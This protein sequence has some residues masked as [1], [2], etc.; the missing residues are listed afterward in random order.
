VAHRRPSSL[1]LIR[2]LLLLVGVLSLLAGGVRAQ[3]EERIVIVLPT[4]GVVDQIMATYLHE[5]IQRGV[6]QGAAAVV[7]ELDTPGGSLESTREIV[8]SELS[9]EVPV[10]VWV[11]PAG[12]RA[13]SAGTFLTLASHVA[14]MAPATNI[15]AATP[16]SSDG[17]DIPDDLGKKVMN[18]TIAT[19]TSIA[20]ERGRPVDWAITTV[21]DAAS[22][23]VDEALAAG[24]IDFKAKSIEDLLAQA[25]GMTVNVAG[26]PVVLQTAGA[27]IDEVGMNP[28]QAFLHLLSDPNIA[29]ILFTL[30]FYGI[31]FELQN[32]NY[33]TGI[34]GAFALILAFIGFGSLPLN[35]AGLLLIAFAVILFVLELSVTS[36]GLLAIGGIVAFALGASALY[37]PPGDP[38]APSVSVAPEVILVMTAITALVFIGVL[39][40]VMK[41]RRAP[42]LDIGTSQIHDP[43]L[44]LGTEGSVRRAL[45]PEGTIYAKGEEWT[46]RSADGRVIERGTAARVV[47]NEGMLLVVEPASAPSPDTQ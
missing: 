37:T 38:V 10:M 16:I 43:L 14:A 34:L 4:T 39:Y 44:P 8:Q 15:G 25:D 47:G 36:G 11:G 41:T 33:V 23:T 32:P 24:A 27:V 29:F 1:T 46:A 6:D 30:G 20:E 5:G 31:F 18:D 19:I 42:D 17:Q 35:I 28:L 45:T 22:Y 12:A 9:A 3:D 2:T 26:E 7:I 13:A 21:E 40:A